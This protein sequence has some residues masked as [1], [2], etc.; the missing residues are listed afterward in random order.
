MKNALRNISIFFAAALLSYLSFFAISNHYAYTET[1]FQ[2]KQTQL[3]LA[4]SPALIY[5]RATSVDV[6]NR[7]I[8]VELNSKKLLTYKL[9]DGA[10]IA[11]QELLGN[12]EVYN[13]LSEPIPSPLSA[14]QV[15]TN[16]SI[17]GYMSETGTLVAGVVLFG[18]PL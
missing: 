5:G 14:I 16:L 15:G 9:I 18:N 2:L 7:S 1:L 6:V 11:K 13:A 12:G 10:Y 8:T 3:A 17:F 4:R